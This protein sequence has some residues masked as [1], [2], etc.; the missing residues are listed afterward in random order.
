[1]EASVQAVLPE[2]QVGLEAGQSEIDEAKAL[3]YRLPYLE[4]LLKDTLEPRNGFDMHLLANAL[5]SSKNYNRNMIAHGGDISGIEFKRVNDSGQYPDKYAVVL[6]DASQV[7]KFRIAYFDQHGF[8]SHHVEDTSERAQQVMVREGFVVEAAGAL[9]QLAST[10]EWDLGMAFADLIM[11]L[12]TGAIKH[13]EFALL[14]KELNDNF[15]REKSE[16]VFA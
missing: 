1:M 6:A 2:T 9:D 4:R 14:Q 16:P 15:T 10:K 13:A 12:N 8:S 3:K 11:K 7:G 5:P